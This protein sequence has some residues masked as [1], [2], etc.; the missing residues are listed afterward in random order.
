MSTY[1]KS[2]KVS[3]TKILYIP[4]IY[5]IIFFCLYFQHGMQVIYPPIYVFN[6]KLAW[7]GDF[8]CN[9]FAY[10]WLATK[11]YSYHLFI[12][13]VFYLIL[14]HWYY[15][16]IIISSYALMKFIILIKSEKLWN[17]LYSIV[18]CQLKLDI[19]VHYWLTILIS[20]IYIRVCII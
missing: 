20:I 8:A 13:S 5:L 15:L 18:I 12:R 16:Q 7:I 9:S 1:H 3:Y 2:Y 10:N 11:I 17:N 4:Y 14:P 19:F 6:R